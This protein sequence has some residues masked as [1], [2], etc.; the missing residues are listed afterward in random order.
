MRSQSIEVAIPVPSG[1]EL[2]GFLECPEAARGVVVFVHGSGSSRYSS[3][4]NLV[5]TLLRRRRFATLL[6]D[7]LTMHEDQVDSMTHEFRFDVPMLAHRVAEVIDWLQYRPGVGALP[8]GLFGASTG[9]AAALFASELRPN[10]INAIV[11]R[12]GRPDLAGDALAMIHVPTLFIVGSE[13]IHVLDLNRSAMIRMP[14][15]KQLITIRGATHLF[16]EPGELEQVA[17]HAANWYSHYLVADQ[18]V[19][20]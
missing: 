17:E 6:M 16:E 14:A 20:P 13:D 18:H 12:G 11:S 19:A 2:K 10:R 1:I 9:A 3:R 5:A 8:I 15:I 7:L 4:N